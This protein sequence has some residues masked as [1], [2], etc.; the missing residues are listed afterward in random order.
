[1]RNMLVAAAL[2]APVALAS[3]AQA[4]D[5]KTV[6]YTGSGQGNYVTSFNSNMGKLVSA[7]LQ[8][9]YAANYA[10]RWFEFQG[11]VP[12]V[13]AEGKFGYDAIGTADYS[14]I[15]SPSLNGNGFATFGISGRSSVFTDS[16]FASFLTPGALP[17]IPFAS[18]GSFT[19][20][21]NGGSVSFDNST[22]GAF[23]S[24]ISYSVSY[25]YD[26]SV[27]AVPEPATWAM[28]LLGF[29]MVAGASR[30]RRRSTA[31][32]YA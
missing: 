10:F 9:N 24:S 5:L 1:M 3:Q 27:A 15:Y 18:L 6:V 17:L 21:P 26:A 8:V 11:D 30:Y 20:S 14:G 12:Q 31:A 4:A 16:D 13:K 2:V 19:F 29:G 7:S 25:L 23:G 28:M 22:P 32:T